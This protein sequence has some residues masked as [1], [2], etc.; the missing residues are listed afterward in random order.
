M[1][2]LVGKVA[3]ITGAGG[4]QGSAEAKLFAS[5]GAKVIATD[6]Q[7]EKAEQVVLDINNQ[8][9][10]SAV[11]VKHDVSSEDDWKTVVQVA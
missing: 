1:T 4:G 10:N 6:I 11:A 8:Y 7:L 9:P 3:I 2:R 5:Q